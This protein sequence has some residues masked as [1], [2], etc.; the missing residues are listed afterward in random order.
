MEETPTSIKTKRFDVPKETYARVRTEVENLVLNRDLIES[1]APTVTRLVF[2]GGGVRGIGFGGSMKFMEE[3]NLTKHVDKIAGSSAGAI[4]AAAIAVGY[5]AQEMIDILKETNFESFKDDGWILS[6][7]IRLMTQYGIYKGDAFY[8]WY[9]DILSRKT[10]INGITFRQLYEKYGKTLVITG[11]CLNRAETYYFNHTDPK[12]ADMPVT[13]AVRISMSIPLFWKAVRL[14]KDD[15]MVDGGVLN[16]FPLYIFDGEFIGDSEVSDEQIER[17]TTI[18][19]KLMTSSE[20]KDSKM[21]HINDPIDS[22]IAYVKSLLNSMLIQIER[23]YIKQG[24]WQQTVCI[25]THDVGSLDFDLS[26]DRKSLLVDE[27]YLAAKNFFHCKSIGEE[28]LMN[29]LIVP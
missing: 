20:R 1:L 17:S 2:E 3:Y 18:G 9:E 14:G 11:T 28:N 12:Y 4:F 8:K 23:G 25:N 16:N 22:P 27:G 5:T 10:Q 29:H 24:Y 13:L 26:E 6:D 19:F 7:L 21:Y 15:V